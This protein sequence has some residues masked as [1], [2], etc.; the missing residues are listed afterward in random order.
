MAATAPKSRDVT[1]SLRYIQPNPPPGAG[2]PVA[3]QR[4]GTIPAEAYKKGRH[5]MTDER[6]V[7]FTDARTMPGGLGGLQFD[8]HGIAVFTPPPPMESY[9]DDARVA[10]EYY[11]KIAQLVKQITGAKDCFIFS[12]LR[13][14][15]S[16]KVVFQNPSRFAHTDASKDSPPAWRRPLVT[17][18]G[19]SEVV[20][21]LRHRVL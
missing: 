20:D 2:L 17:K 10:G 3:D 1:A 21:G 11:P 9:E 13:R 8:T 18:Y 14:E 19:Y 6:T 7:Q 15:P 5:L 12:H 16:P 4:Y